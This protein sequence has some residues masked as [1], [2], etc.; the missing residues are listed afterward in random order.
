MSGG[1]ELGT[2]LIMW[3]RNGKDDTNVAKE[4]VKVVWPRVCEGRS[5]VHCAWATS[6]GTKV[7]LVTE[8]ESW[9]RE[10]S[11]RCERHLIKLGYFCPGCQH[12]L[13]TV[14]NNIES[15]TQ[16]PWCMEP[17]P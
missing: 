4:V 15:R 1:E 5:Q 12:G 13:C 6:C 3:L 10:H 7:D 8:I 9:M 16:C 17:F 14:C 11:T 2:A